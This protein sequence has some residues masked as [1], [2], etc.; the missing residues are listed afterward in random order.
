VRSSLID[1]TRANLAEFVER[2]AHHGS[3][4]PAIADR[5]GISESQVR[6]I[7][8]HHQIPAGERRWLGKGA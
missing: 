1:A 5:L 8:R 4:D 2:L 7:R 3:S 6:K